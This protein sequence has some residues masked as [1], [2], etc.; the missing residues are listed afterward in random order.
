M[1]HSEGDV[2]G[3]SWERTRFWQLHGRLD[4]QLVPDK[5][6][7]WIKDRCCARSGR[8]T[9][10]CERALSAL[11]EK[12]LLGAIRFL[13]SGD[14]LDLVPMLTMFN[15]AD[16]E[17]EPSQG[18]DSHASAEVASGN[19]ASPREIKD[20]DGNPGSLNL[21]SPSKR[22]MPQSRAKKKRRSCTGR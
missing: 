9:T 16:L 15:Q 2:P 21:A 5:V 1:G 3:K 10:N 4:H 18:L 19:L 12:E 11:S 20:S 13:S 7:A 8:K 6:W 14:E 22:G 17:T